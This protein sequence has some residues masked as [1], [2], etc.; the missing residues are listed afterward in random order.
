M[1]IRDRFAVENVERREYLMFVLA[2]I[3]C[4]METCEISAQRFGDIVQLMLEGGESCYVCLLYT[5]WV[6]ERCHNK[7][8]SGDGR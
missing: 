8:A 7:C 2:M 5:S 3:Y 1:C 6:L 4:G